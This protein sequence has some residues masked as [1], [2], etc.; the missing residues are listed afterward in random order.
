MRAP[1]IPCTHSGGRGHTDVTSLSFHWT[2]LNRRESKKKKIFKM[3]H[4]QTEQRPS[5]SIL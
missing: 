2:A 5:L 4:S 1:R 3:Q